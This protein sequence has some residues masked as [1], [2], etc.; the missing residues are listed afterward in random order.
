MKYTLGEIVKN[1]RME[2]G[3][4]QTGLSKISGVDCKTISLIERNIRKR[5]LLETLLNLSEALQIYD[6]LLFDACGYTTEEMMEAFGE[7]KIHKSFPFDFIITIKGDAIVS[8][9]NEQSARDIAAGEISKEIVNAS[10]NNKLLNE[11]LHGSKMTI[12]IDLKER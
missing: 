6:D 7:V 11:I 9:D 1:K 8:A 5:P 3:L 10:N 4:T 2:L 12:K